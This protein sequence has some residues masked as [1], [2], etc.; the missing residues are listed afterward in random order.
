MRKEAS[1]WCLRFLSIIGG[2]VPHIFA[3]DGGRLCEHA[4]IEQVAMD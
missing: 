3:C 1:F 4:S 2:R